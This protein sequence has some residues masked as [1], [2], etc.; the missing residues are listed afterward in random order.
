MSVADAVK[1]G[2]LPVLDKDHTNMFTLSELRLYQHAECHAAL[3]LRIT[4]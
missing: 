3:T 2:F 4:G 1:A